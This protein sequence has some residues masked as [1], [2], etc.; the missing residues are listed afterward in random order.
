MPPTDG[1]EATFDPQQDPA[2]DTLA[3]GT[4]D[5]DQDDAENTVDWEKRYRDLQSFTTKRI[6]QLQSQLMGGD[7]G[8]EDAEE[9]DDDEE[10]DDAGTASRLEQQ[11][12]ALAE[13]MFGGAAIKAYERAAKLMDRAQTPADYVAAFEAYHQARIGGTK[14]PNTRQQA[15]ADEPSQPVDANR[16]DT[17]PRTDFDRQA[18]EARA[19]GNSLAWFQAQVRRVRGE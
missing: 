16:P 19:S 9:E 18:E 15:Q 7:E 2:E 17:S 10:P 8:D 11:N 14:K 4:E 3:D 13:Q 5:T 1:L 6:E 12:W